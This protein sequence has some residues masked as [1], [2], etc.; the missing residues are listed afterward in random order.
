MGIVFIRKCGG[1]TPV[2]F[3][4]TGKLVGAWT[5]RFEQKAATAKGLK[6]GTEKIRGFRRSANTKLVAKTYWLFF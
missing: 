6:E 3:L 5:V 2:F 1:Y 4:G